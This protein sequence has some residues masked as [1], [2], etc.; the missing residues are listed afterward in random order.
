MATVSQA[1]E[2]TIDRLDLEAKVKEMYRRVARE[3]R[4][5]FPFETGR[6]VAER[7]GYPSAELDRIPAEAV[8]AFSGAGYH[9][10][11]A[12]IRA[13]ETVLDLGSGVGM[14]T[15]FA[16][17][18]AGDTGHVSGVDMTEEPL[19][20]AERL[21]TA[22]GFRTVSFH[23]A[24]I[25]DLPF[26]DASM[27]VVLGNG[28]FILCADKALAFREAA[29]VLPYGGRLAV[30][31]IVT[32]RALPEDMVRDAALWAACVGG[33]M[34]RDLYRRALMEAGFR[35]AAVRENPQ[36]RFLSDA[37]REA[38]ATYGVKS[39]SLLAIKERR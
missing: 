35:V 2:R 12:A 10:D 14:D 4:G 18:R 39:L 22:A 29:R 8:D 21:R 26:D 25:E 5:R 6:A 37:A 30:S 27:D 3:P 11:L 24:Y 9:M 23:R 19:R 7:L 28:V 16:A 36:Y 20:K 17:L 33:A 34:P 1:V 31:D 32:E 13:G 38:S 15:F